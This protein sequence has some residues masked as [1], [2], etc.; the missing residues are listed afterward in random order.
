MIGWK[1]VIWYNYQRI[2]C[3]IV[4]CTGESVCVVMRRLCCS[5]ILI[6]H[7]ERHNM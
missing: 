4:M 7:D 2:P 3:L 5:D 1:C 6:L